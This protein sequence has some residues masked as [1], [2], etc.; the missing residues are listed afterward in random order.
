[1]PHKKWPG[2]YCSHMHKVP[3]VSYMQLHCSQLNLLAGRLQCRVLLPTRHVLSQNYHCCQNN[4]LLHLVQGNCQ[5]QRTPFT[6]H[7][8]DRAL[9]QRMN[10]WINLA[11]K[12]LMAPLS[13][14]LQNMV[15][16]RHPCRRKKHLTRKG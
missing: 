1:M 7:S 5:L 6:C 11:S 13:L 16:G 2:I 8:Y 10:M 15:V 3:L 12:Q 9:M 14:F 4:H